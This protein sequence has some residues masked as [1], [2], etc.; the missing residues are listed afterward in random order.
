VTD[1]AWERRGAASGLGVVL[2]GAAATAF[3]RASMTAADFA[4]DRTALVTQSMIRRAGS[5][6]GRRS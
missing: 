6:T 3:E 5:D 2:P 1:H 4:A